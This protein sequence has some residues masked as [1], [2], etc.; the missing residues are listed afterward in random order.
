M[1]FTRRQ[2][3]F[4]IQALRSGSLQLESDG[5]PCSICGD[6]GH[7]AFECGRNP[8]VA[9]SI[10]KSIAE[11]ADELHE[12]LHYLA[13]SVQSMGT[14]RGPAKVILPDRGR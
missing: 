14:I 11:S 5:K 1:K 8:L 12:T 3:D 2:Y 10:C 13:G 7:Q 6:D 9:M 4:A